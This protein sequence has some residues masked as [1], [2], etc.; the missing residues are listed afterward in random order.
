MVVSR[1]LV[2]RFPHRLVDKP[3]VSRLVKEFGLEF[4]ILRAAVT[5]GEEGLL[6]MELMGERRDYDKGVQYLTA[7][8]CVVRTAVPAWLY[9]PR[10]FLPLTRRPAK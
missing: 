6:V 3:I 5:P 2:L 7:M 8:N 1:R 4:N 9:A 10:G